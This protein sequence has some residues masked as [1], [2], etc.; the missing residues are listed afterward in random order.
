MKASLRGASRRYAKALLD[1]A[2]KLAVADAVRSELRAID[3]LVSEHWELGT[4]LVNPAVKAARKQAILDEVL[5]RAAG[6]AK[7]P[8]AQLARRLAAVLIQRDR[9]ALFS[10]IAD[11]FTE[12]WNEERGVVTAQAVSAEP[13]DADQ[14]RAIAAAVEKTTGR[15]AEVTTQLDPSVIGGVKLLMGGRT[16]DG[17]VKAQLAA[18]R[19]RLTGAAGRFDQGAIRAAHGR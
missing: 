2:R 10:T 5:D 1:V 19:R 4:L 6:D 9:F 14:A 12:L 18:L 11:V 17:T 8:A 15:K 3:D 13:L 7:E 16:Y